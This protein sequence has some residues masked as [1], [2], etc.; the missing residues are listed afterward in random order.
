MS[1]LTDLVPVR[2][3]TGVCEVTVSQSTVWMGTVKYQRSI[4]L[5]CQQT[6]V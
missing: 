2:E 6:L 3:W 1:K 5:R 4:T